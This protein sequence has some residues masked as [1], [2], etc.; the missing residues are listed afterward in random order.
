MHYYW[1]KD[2]THFN[3][4][5]QRLHPFLWLLRQGVLDVRCLMVTWRR[6]DRPLLMTFLLLFAL[7]TF[8]YT[9]Q[10]WWLCWITLL[11]MFS[12][13]L[14]D[15]WESAVGWDILV[16]TSDVCHLLRR[17]RGQ[18]ICVKNIYICTHIIHTYICI[19]NYVCIHICIYD[20]YIHS[21]TSH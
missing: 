19:Y 12:A 7:Y 6:P 9:E 11:K 17:H 1:V 18:N 8:L 3:Q 4:L 13:A 16:T 14:P 10:R 15:W 21:R 5:F 2:Y 20:F